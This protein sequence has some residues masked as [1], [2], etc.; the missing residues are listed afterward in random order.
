M[1]EIDVVRQ[2]MYANPLNGLILLDGLNDL[3]DLWMFLFDLFVTVHADL[4]RRNARISTSLRT[5]MAVLAG[6]LQRPCMNRVAVRYGLSGGIALVIRL[7]G[8]RQ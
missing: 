6:D 3:L 1:I 5:E 8:H 4:S 7:T 2:V